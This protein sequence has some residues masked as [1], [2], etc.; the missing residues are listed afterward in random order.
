M[1]AIPF[2]PMLV[3]GF[4]SASLRWNPWMYLT[5][6]GELESSKGSNLVLCLLLAITFTIVATPWYICYVIYAGCIRVIWPEH[7]EGTGLQSKA[8]HFKSMEVL[9]ESALQ[10]S[11]SRFSC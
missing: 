4:G 1:I 3:H 11:L 9:L 2:L 6:C 7:E 10:T 8:A 5:S